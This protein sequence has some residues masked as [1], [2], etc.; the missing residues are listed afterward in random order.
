V[1]PAKAAETIRSLVDEFV[2]LATPKNFGALGRWYQD[3]SEI[4][5]EEASQM[6]GIN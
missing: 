5:H 3:F 4:T 2:C 1:A 6:L